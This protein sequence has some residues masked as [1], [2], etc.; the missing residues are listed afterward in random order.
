MFIKIKVSELR[1]ALTKPVTEAHPYLSKALHWKDDNNIV[2]LN[3]DK[4]GE[5]IL[6]KIEAYAKVNHKQPEF[7]VICQSISTYKKNSC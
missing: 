7:N 6:D 1:K 3:V 5:A 2:S 4:F